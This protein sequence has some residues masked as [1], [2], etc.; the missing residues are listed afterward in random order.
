LIVYC[1]CPYFFVF[2]CQKLL[3]HS[4]VIMTYIFYVNFL[5][6]L[7]CHV[8]FFLKLIGCLNPIIKYDW[9][10]E[11]STQ[12]W[13]VERRCDF[14]TNR[15]AMS[16]IRAE[17]ALLWTNQFAGNTIDFKMNIIKLK[18]PEIKL[19]ILFDQRACYSKF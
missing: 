19:K 7:I 18:I 9:L 15:T 2:M 12:L 3:R 13:L 17:I 10:V 14:S 1:S 11:V 8:T 4:R 16:A 5:F 6:L